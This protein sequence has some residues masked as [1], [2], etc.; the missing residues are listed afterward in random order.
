MRTSSVGIST[1]L[2][3]AASDAFSFHTPPAV[4]RNLQKQAF[5]LPSGLSAS[6]EPKDLNTKVAVLREDKSS[7]EA[8]LGVAV[9]EGDEI[10]GVSLAT[11]KNN[12]TQ[13]KDADGLVMALKN[14]NEKRTV[15]FDQERSK[16]VK[17][18]IMQLLVDVE[19]EAENIAR[20]MLDEECE[21]DDKGGP[22][23]E[24]CADETARSG[25]RAYLKGTVGKT[26]KMVRG[27]PSDE[28]DDDTVQ[29]EGFQGDLLEKGWGDRG[30][31]SSIRRNAEV[32][33][34]ALKC[35]FR[36]LKPRSL[37]K[38]G[39]PEEEIKQAQN[40]AATF[41][42]DGLLTLG[43]TFVKLGKMDG[44]IKSLQ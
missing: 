33:K 14:F 2:L 25:F 17:D 23:D 5:R 29:A 36:A 26:L 41:I 35:A 32:W 19:E 4:K 44:W 38:K 15:D 31:V 27:L 21:F 9:T 34:F 13:L 10:V 1:W 20:E 30:G 37:R 8:S 39:A 43:P 7:G 28:E 16:D 3:L 24:L 22:T 6:A 40:D 12:T 42:R 18:D 11:L